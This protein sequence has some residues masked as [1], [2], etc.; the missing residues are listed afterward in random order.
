MI[1]K[2][3]LLDLLLSPIFHLNLLDLTQAS[4]LS[5]LFRVREFPLQ[6]HNWLR[7]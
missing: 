7:T 4:A 3:L 5:Q 6:K 1:Y 2:I